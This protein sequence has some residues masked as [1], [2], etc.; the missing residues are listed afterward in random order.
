M[1]N[2][3]S[4]RH[5]FNFNDV[6]QVNKEGLTIEIS[7]SNWWYLNDKEIC[8]QLRKLLDCLHTI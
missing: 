6:Y 3:S 1:V 7:P 4:E 8:M 5:N 2:R